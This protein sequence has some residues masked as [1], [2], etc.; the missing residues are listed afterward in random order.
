M[1]PTIYKF[2]SFTPI[3]FSFST[4]FFTSSIALIA[5]NCPFPGEILPANI[6]FTTPIP[7]L[8]NSPKTFLVGISYLLILIPSGRTIILFSATSDINLFFTHSEIAIAFSAFR[9]LPNCFLGLIN[10]T[11]C[12]GTINSLI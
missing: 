10:S 12:S 9:N 11:L 4:Y 3:I 6:R 2:I 7:S 8:C 1:L 5:S